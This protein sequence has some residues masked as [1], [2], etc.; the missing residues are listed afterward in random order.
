MTTTSTLRKVLDMKAWQACNPSP[1][2]NAA[3]MFTVSSD[4]GDQLT[5]Y[6]TSGTVIW[7]YDPSEDAWSLLPSPALATFAAG[8]TGRWHPSGPTGTAS[9]GGAT[10]I[11]TTTT[12]LADLAPRGGVYHKIRITSGT[13]AGQERLIAS[14]SMGA[15]SIVT[16]TQAWDTNPDATS[17]YLLLTGRVWLFGGGTLA[18]GSFKYWDY[19][20]QT[21]SGNRSI[22][23]VSATFGT[24]GRLIGTHS[25]R[26]TFGTGTATSGASTTLTQTGKTW[27]VN[28]WTNYQVRITAGTGAGQVRTIASNTATALTVSSAW[29]TN[30]DAT[31]VYV[32]EGNDD[33]MYLM[34]NAAV[35]LYRYSIS[36]DTWSTLTPGAARAGAPIV[37]AN[38][39]WVTGVT[40]ADWQSEN[41]I[42]NGQ[43]L[44]SFR[45]TNVLDYYDIAANTWVSGVTYG[46]QNETV[47]AAGAC[48]EY[49]GDNYLYISLPATLNAPTRYLRLDFRGP[50]LEGF[51][52]NVFPAPAAAT[53]GDKFFGAQFVD[54]ATALNFV[55]RLADG[56]TQLHRCLAF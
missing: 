3:N 37:G 26:G 28:S 53:L 33:F 18:A 42:R 30:P 55:Y 10:T 36:G 25:T 19:A 31:S 12:V 44:Y 9:A 51:S 2:I 32:I 39:T 56:N 13:G 47:A 5:Y 41:T 27:T 34:G 21:W 24:D 48:H 45:S 15:N 43:R 22:T 38:L 7:V 52:T 35:T 14:A 54:G 49:F 1:V 23:G 20:T 40:Q 8:T 50:A 29:G 17:V 16:V 11:T 46:R 6:V 4:G